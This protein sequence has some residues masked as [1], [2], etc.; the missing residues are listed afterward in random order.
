MENK[1]EFIEIIQQNEG[2]IFKVARVYTNTKEDERDLYQEIIY[3]LWKSFASFRRESKLSTWM[4]R[5]AL[6]TAIA[7][8]NK[9]KRKGYQIPIDEILLNKSDVPD[10]LA[11]ERSEV[12][13]AHIKRLSDPEKGIILLYLEGKNYEEIA[14]I[15]GFTAT[16]VG[17][18]LGRIKQKLMSQIN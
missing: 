1:K 5:I 15:T 17:T 12:L 11:D 10:T 13:F 16:N 9:E 3:Q 18:R 8:L 2:L 7:Q 4:Y 6:N 14:T